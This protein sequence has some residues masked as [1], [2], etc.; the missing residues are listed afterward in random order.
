MLGRIDDLVDRFKGGVDRSVAESDL[1]NGLVAFL[2]SDDRSRRREVARMD[3]ETVKFL[4]PVV[5][6]VIGLAVI[7]KS[8]KVSVRNLFFLIAELFELVKYG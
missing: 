3:V 2:K 7:D 1:F 5:R 4:H 8:F 6:S